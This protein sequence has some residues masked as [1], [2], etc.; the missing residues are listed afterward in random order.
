MQQNSFAA[1]TPI[2]TATPYQQA[3]E[4]PQ[5]STP[6]SHLPPVPENDIKRGLG[7]DNSETLAEA[8]KRIA[9]LESEL[10]Q[11]RKSSSGFSTA[12]ATK[13]VQEGVPLQMVAG[14]A[15]S[16]FIITYLFL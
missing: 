2:I 1:T 12:T 8:K 11:L 3:S 14:I 10:T 6:L 16:V 7:I 15:I 4:L 9:A 13:E 5:E